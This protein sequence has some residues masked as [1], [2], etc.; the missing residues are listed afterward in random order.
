MDYKKEYELLL[1]KHNEQTTE[2]KNT[3]TKL[4]KIKDDFDDA[5]NII[6]QLCKQIY[7][8][9]C[10][11][12][13]NKDMNI[14]EHFQCNTISNEIICNNKN[15]F[16]LII[17]LIEHN[18]FEI[19]GIPEEFQNDK[20]LLFNITKKYVKFNKNMSYQYEETE[21]ISALEN[22]SYK[23]QNDEGII[24]HL[25]IDLKDSEALAFT[26]DTLTHNKKFICN[27][28]SN[29]VG[30]LDTIK[31]MHK[32]LQND[33]DFIL[34]IHNTYNADSKQFYMCDAYHYLSEKLQQNFDIVMIIINEEKY[35]CDN[36][37][38]LPE[39]IIHSRKF[40]IA[41][42]SNIENNI[43]NFEEKK[44]HINYMSNLPE[45]YKQEIKFYDTVFDFDKLK[46]EMWKENGI[47]Q[48]LAEY[49]G[50]P[51]KLNF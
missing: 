41:Y 8:N 36:F 10:D 18:P 42:L 46:K 33:Y 24:K 9:L 47:A 3:K 1:L 48:G 2:L 50:H 19:C 27:L 32:D 13:I 43:Q 37:Y 12:I 51:D 30:V 7:D 11:Y 29:G 31:Y 49:F 15:K 17:K 25:I 45:Q 5:N 6:T 16:S 44:E 21:G 38:Y 26:G 22:F 23:L 39:N 14:I 4:N 35:V 34:Y 40:I 28:L 20:E